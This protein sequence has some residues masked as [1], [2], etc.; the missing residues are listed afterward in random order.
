MNYQLNTKYVPKLT[1]KPIY[2][3]MEMMERKMVDCYD[4]IDMALDAMNRTEGGHR[5]AI[6]G[7]PLYVRECSPNRIGFPVEIRVN[8]QYVPR[9]R[10]YFKT[11]EIASAMAE[12]IGL[13]IQY[14]CLKK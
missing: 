2:H 5:N 7:K 1:P 8:G 9:A 6:I 13:H 12:Q 3:A 14:E 11:R 4:I 10:V